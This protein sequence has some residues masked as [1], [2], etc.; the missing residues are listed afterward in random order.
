MG[1]KI[2]IQV[3]MLIYNLVPNH[4]NKTYMYQWRGSWGWIGLVQSHTPSWTS[5]KKHKV[6]NFMAEIMAKSPDKGKCN[7][8]FVVLLVFVV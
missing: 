5:Q 1:S 2:R 4:R 8:Y 3:R 6:V 7:F